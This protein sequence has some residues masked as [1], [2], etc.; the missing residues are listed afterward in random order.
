MTYIILFII[1]YAV[2]LLVFMW[3]MEF[4]IK[5]EWWL[6]L[7]IAITGPLCIIEAINIRYYEG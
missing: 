2:G 5:G 4:D 7:L 3:S 1:W 6:A